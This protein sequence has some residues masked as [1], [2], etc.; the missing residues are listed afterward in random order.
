MGL[1]ASAWR[2]ANRAGRTAYKGHAPRLIV[3]FNVGICRS[4]LFRCD[5]VFAARGGEEGLRH[6]RD[7]PSFL[8]VQTG[9]CEVVGLHV[10]SLG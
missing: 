4:W 10:A 2:L 6:V 5:A 3:P 9:H 1:P 7:G 8:V